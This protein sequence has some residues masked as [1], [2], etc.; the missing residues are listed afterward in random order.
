[1]AEHAPVGIIRPDIRPH[2]RPDV[3][4]HGPVQKA[5]AATTPQVIDGLPAKLR[6]MATRGHQV[7]ARDVATLITAAQAI[8][9][10]QAMLERNMHTYAKMIGDLVEMR[11][12]LLS[13][14]ELM[15]A[16]LDGEEEV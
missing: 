10:Q 14:R 5:T 16:G 7:R 8:E 12:Q 11:T 1:M 3:R 9:A 6:T 15:Q 4:P 13:L 2:V